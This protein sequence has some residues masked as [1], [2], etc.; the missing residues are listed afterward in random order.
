MTENWHPIADVVA[1]VLEELR[2]PAVRP[3]YGPGNDEPAAGPEPS[4]RD[5]PP[6]VW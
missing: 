5:D 3:G 6:D 2:R 4:D 1:E